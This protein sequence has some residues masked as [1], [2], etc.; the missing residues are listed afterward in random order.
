MRRHS[1]R[2][3]KCAVT[4]LAIAVIAVATAPNAIAAPKPPWKAL[5]EAW[6]ALKQAWRESPEARFAVK[7]SRKT[8]TRALQKYRRTKGAYCP[9]RSSFPTYCRNGSAVA[10]APIDFFLGERYVGSVG[11]GTVLSAAC[12]F[13][14]AGAVFVRVLWPVP[15]VPSVFVSMG[16]L[17]LSL[18]VLRLPNC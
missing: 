18:D 2:T 9:W 3:I 5:E 8:A 10:A 12:S 4:I 17:R 11:T 6:G 15:R 14:R 7:V 13:N 16:L 1:A